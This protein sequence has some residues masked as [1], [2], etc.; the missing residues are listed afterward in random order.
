MLAT[1]LLPEHLATPI[2]VSESSAMPR[3]THNGIAFESSVYISNATYEAEAFA[4]V[5][6]LGEIATKAV[7]AATPVGNTYVKATAA[8]MKAAFEIYAG[9]TVA[10]KEV[11]PAAQAAQAVHH[12]KMLKDLFLGKDEE[13]KEDSRDLVFAQTVYY[14]GKVRSPGR[15]FLQQ[16]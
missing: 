1:P 8:D 14:V 7:F 12:Q 11:P 5:A 3:I 16:I 2:L 4:P 9:I 6:P 13:E 15:I 10:P